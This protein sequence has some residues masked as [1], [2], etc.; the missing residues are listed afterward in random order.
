M[1][2][3]LSSSAGFVLVKDTRPDEPAEVLSTSTSE[4][5]AATAG[6]IEDAEAPPPE[7][8]EFSAP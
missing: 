7:P 6:R 5:A 8:F 1:P 2:L 4:A 3:K